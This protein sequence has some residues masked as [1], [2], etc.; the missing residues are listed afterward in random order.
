V[1]EGSER[2]HDLEPIRVLVAEDDAASRR[3]LEVVLVRWGYDVVTASDGREALER[4]HE[5]RPHVVLLDWLMPELDGPDVCREIR[6]SPGGDATQLILV[7]AKSERSDIVEGLES[8]ADGHLAK[9]W[10]N[11]ELRAHLTVAERMLRRHAALQSR[12]SE[13]EVTRGENLPEGLLGM[14]AY[15]RKVRVDDDH[16]VSLERYLFEHTTIRFSHGICS[17]C[18][19]GVRA[20]MRKGTEG[21]R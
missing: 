21:D 20:E 17:T 16:W 6:V 11:A 12:V 14:C 3:R 18:Y 5:H 10:S 19:P 4:Y 2:A 7:S 9:P 15:C 8:G 13:L 1:A